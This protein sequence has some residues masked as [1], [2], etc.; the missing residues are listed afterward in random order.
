VGREREERCFADSSGGFRI[1]SDS[2]A[3][4]LKRLLTSSNEDDLSGKVPH[5]RIGVERGHFGISV[6]ACYWLIDSKLSVDL[7]E[8]GEQHDIYI[9]QDEN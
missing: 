7:P 6:L 2:A 3:V 5:V 8:L 9:Q 1:R 4:N